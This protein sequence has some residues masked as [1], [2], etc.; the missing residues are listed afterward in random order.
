MPPCD[1]FA[2]PADGGV[3]DFGANGVIRLDSA[4]GPEAIE[5]RSFAIIESE[6]QEPRPF[7][8]PAWQVARRL[9]H[10]SGDLSLLS[11]LYL[12]DAAVRAGVE[13]LKKGRP[14][15]AD[16]AMAVAG[17]PARRLA[18]LGV[19]AECFLYGAG[20]AETARRLGCTRAK[21]GIRA[22]SERMGSSVLAI[23]NAPT[24]LLA[25]FDYLDSGGEPPALVIAM[26]VG[27]VNAAESKEL[28]LRRGDLA[29]LAVRGRRG[30]SPLAAATVNALACLA[31]E[32][33]GLAPAPL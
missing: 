10:S 11:S 16:T 9:V 5:R 13:A 14:V 30:G 2:A 6:V 19:R 7:A 23:G 1:R 25:L 28:A 12:P 15:Y 22:L 33:S 17:M 26:P 18:P 29:V 31:L 4:S 27:F 21:A 8:G 32:E 20:V 24:A 3:A